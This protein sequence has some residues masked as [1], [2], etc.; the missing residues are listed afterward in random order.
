METT[1]QGQVAESIKIGPDVVT[2]KG[3][4][5]TID[6]KHAMPD[7]QVRE[8][9]PM[10]IYFRDKKYMLRRKM[11]GEKPF[12]MRYFLEP[13]REGAPQGNCTFSYDEETVTQREKALLSGH[14]DDV[15]HAA[16]IFLYPFLGLLWSNTKEKLRRFNFDPRGLTGFSVFVVF[17][18]V[19]LELVFAKMLIFR[20]LK[21][22][23]V[24]IGGM[25]R[26]FTGV[27]SFSLGPVEIRMLW[28]DVAL[29]LLLLAD[30][31]IRY[32]QHLHGDEPFWGFL[33][34][35]TRLKRRKKP[36]N[37]VKLP[38]PAAV[39]QRN[40]APEEPGGPIRMSR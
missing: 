37:I 17:G 6:A 20:S 34:W 5:V 1:E 36:T 30:V 22:G 40:K 28:L 35:L 23:N 29:F 14:M 38:D 21:T 31:F 11:A 27:D 2:I 19:L 13:W 25:L 12:A 3:D 10:P 8:F 7:W 24:V 26:A 33:E 39:I 4:Q 32:S 16:L 18:F 9:S 15:G